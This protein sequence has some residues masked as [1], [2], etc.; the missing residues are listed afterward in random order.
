M[1]INLLKC[2]FFCGNI[3]NSYVSQLRRYIDVDVYGKC[4]KYR[5]SIDDPV[6]CLDMLERR[7][8]FY[9]S[10][11]N[12]LCVD[13]VTEKFLR[14]LNRNVIAVVLG[15]ANYSNLVPP[16]TYL[17]VRN[18]R[19]PSQLAARMRELVANGGAQYKQ[20]LSQK[21]NVKCTGTSDHGG[22]AFAERLCKYLD[23]TR[24]QRQITNLDEVWNPK[25]MCLEPR[26]FYHGVTDS[27][28][29]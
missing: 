22:N 8:F 5:C 27:I 1:V 4:G 29:G 15:A 10:F 20:M 23:E 12:S 28:T 19:S 17:D 18:F 25:K 3:F 24:N 16:S 11:E 9:L 13:Y 21:R 26:I 6:K 7:Y 14:L 2:A